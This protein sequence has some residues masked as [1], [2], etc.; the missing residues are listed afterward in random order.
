[1]P[2]LLHSAFVVFINSFLLILQIKATVPAGIFLRK[3]CFVGSLTNASYSAA[4]P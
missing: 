3:A 1:M 2:Q 4:G